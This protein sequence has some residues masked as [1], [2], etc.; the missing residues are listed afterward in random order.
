M[1]PRG[2][3]SRAGTPISLIAIHTAEGATAAHG[4]MRFLDQPAVEASY[5]KLADD[6]EV[7]TY[8]PDSEACWAMLSGNPRAVQLCFTGFAA[9][10]R[11]EWL[12]HDAMLRRGALEV[13]RW[14]KLH[15]VP[16]VKL[17]PAQVG[18]DLHGICGHGDWTLG[19]RDGNHT[20]PG[21]NFPWPEFIAM[22]RAH[23][24]VNDMQQDERETLLD[25]RMQ[26]TGSTHLGQYPGWAAHPDVTPSAKT[27]LDYI[28]ALHAQQQQHTTL[29]AEIL[30]RLP[31]A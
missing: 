27:L 9:W 10:S 5:H 26:L 29:L 18:A 31:K 2:S 22:V 6:V 25:I 12:A 30:G 1:I 17:S 13:A 11:V 24:E 28:R 14:C 21:P 7:I 19:K 8:L 4:L 15:A 23:M 20:D 16:P 3:E